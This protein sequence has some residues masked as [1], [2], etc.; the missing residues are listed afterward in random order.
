MTS[1]FPL[2]GPLAEALEDTIELLKSA[3]VE[4]RLLEIPVTTIAAPWSRPETNAPYRA[5][6]ERVAR[7]TGT[8][9]VRLPA[10]LLEDSDFFD[11]VHL[12]ADG[13]RKLSRWLASDVIVALRNSDRVRV[14]YNGR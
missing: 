11:P 7:A 2:R 1:G 6:V 12:H 4:V 9:V 8:R 5:I 13:A 14:S 10:G 3:G